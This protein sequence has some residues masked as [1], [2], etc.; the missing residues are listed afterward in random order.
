MSLIGKK[1]GESAS[2]GLNTREDIEKM[3]NLMRYV[4]NCSLVQGGGTH[5][6][7]Q[8]TESHGDRPD[9]HMLIQ[10]ALLCGENCLS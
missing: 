7:A 10:Q 8:A 1:K 9:P 3:R 5:I 6:Q 4:Y 2:R